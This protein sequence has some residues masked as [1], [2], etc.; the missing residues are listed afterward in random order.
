[1][2]TRTYTYACCATLPYSQAQLLAIEACNV[3]A[4]IAIEDVH[5]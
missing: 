5:H 2:R 1:M 4:E 3:G